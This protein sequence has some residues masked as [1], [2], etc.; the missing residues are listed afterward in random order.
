MTAIPGNAAAKPRLTTACHWHG[1]H[2][3]SGNPAGECQ[4]KVNVFPH[5]LVDCE[6]PCHRGEAG[7]PAASPVARGEYH[8]RR[9]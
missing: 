4:G 3:G 8:P 7:P 5:G 6:C 1:R 2:A 9:V